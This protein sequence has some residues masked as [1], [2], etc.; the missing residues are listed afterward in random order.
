M[1]WLSTV[2][3]YCRQYAV[4]AVEFISAKLTVMSRVLEL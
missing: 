4:Q 2:G 3:L 1:E